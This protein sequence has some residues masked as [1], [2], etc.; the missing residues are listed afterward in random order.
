VDDAE[1]EGGHAA[2]TWVLPKHLQVIRK[3]KPSER[4]RKMKR[5]VL[6]KDGGGSPTANPLTLD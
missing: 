5:V 1:G 3:R 6:G 2:V 4:I